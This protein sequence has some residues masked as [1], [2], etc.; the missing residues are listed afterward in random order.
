MK[1]LKSNSLYHSIRNFPEENTSISDVLLVIKFLK[2]VYPVGW[3]AKDNPVNYAH[4]Y[5][6]YNISKNE[7][8]EI[9]QEFLKPI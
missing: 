9:L 6:V 7:K 8:M 3:Y 2:I 5:E 4:L 1:R